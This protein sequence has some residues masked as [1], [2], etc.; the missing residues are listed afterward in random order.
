MKAFIIK[1]FIKN[2]RLGLEVIHFCFAIETIGLYVFD[3]VIDIFTIMNLTFFSTFT[4]IVTKI[5]ILTSKKNNSR[6]KPNIALSS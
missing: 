4:G 1:G 6:K 2:L 3:P 5:P